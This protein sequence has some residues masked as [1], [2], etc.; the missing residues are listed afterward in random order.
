MWI[1]R[2]SNS[3]AQWSTIADSDYLSSSPNKRLSALGTKMR[4]CVRV[5]ACCLKCSNMPVAPMCTWSPAIHLMMLIWWLCPW[6]WC[7]QVLGDSEST[8]QRS[9]SLGLQSVDGSEPFWN[10]CIELWQTFCR[11]EVCKSQK[12]SWNFHGIILINSWPGKYEKFW[13]E[14]LSPNAESWISM[15]FPTATWYAKIPGSSGP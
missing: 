13:L 10:V 11:S 5:C 15:M 1:Y 4:G 8:P 3:F 12:L 7:R 14:T 6:I 9:M 2:L